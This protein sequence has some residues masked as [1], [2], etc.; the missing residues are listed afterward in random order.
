MAGRFLLGEHAWRLSFGRWL[1]IEHRKS[2]VIGH[3]WTLR[4]SAIVQLNQG[5]VTL[6]LLR[7]LSDLVYLKILI[8]EVRHVKLK[9]Y[10]QYQAAWDREDRPASD[11]V[12][13]YV[14]AC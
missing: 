2:R 8:V 13:E 14:P 3:S 1:S 4:H 7:L 9:E 10:K 12:V 6:S 11:L 5:L